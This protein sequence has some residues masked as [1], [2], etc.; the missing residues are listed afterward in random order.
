M[1][2]LHGSLLSLILHGVLAIAV[3]SHLM[4]EEKPPSPPLAIEVVFEKPKS[5]VS[6]APSHH[7]IEK[8]PL[9]SIEKPS[10]RGFTTG[11]KT[12]IRL[13]SLRRQGSTFLTESAVDSQQRG[14][15]I[16]CVKTKGLD[17]AIKLQ[18]DDSESLS[19]MSSLSS[20][21]DKSRPCTPPLQ[22][23]SHE[24]LSNPLPVY[25]LIARKRGHE[26]GVILRL[27]ISNH[28]DCEGVQIKTS[29]GSTF[30]DEAA[31]AAVKSWKFTPALR[32]VSPTSDEIDV[33]FDFRLSGVELH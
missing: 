17:T 12:T 11:S 8:R 3:G 16:D 18:D 5:V 24:G 20:D 7:I 29:S 6:P 2:N 25:P 31:I 10:S 22:R 21:T 30:L 9:D 33:T 19:E 1:M 28:G 4:G 23:A 27:K 14:N 15:D 26:G 32:G 13:S